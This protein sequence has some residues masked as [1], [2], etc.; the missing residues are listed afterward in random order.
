M[1]GKL[2]ILT[3]G[4]VLLLAG[5]CKQ[6]YPPAG[7]Y[8]KD[9]TY[10]ERFSVP[11]DTVIKIPGDSVSIALPAVILNADSIPFKPVVKR[12][13]RATLTVK[14]NKDK[15]LNIGC[16][17][18]SAAIAAKVLDTYIQTH[19]QQTK[20]VT[21]TLPPEKYIPLF[22]KTLAWTGGIFLLLLA[23][24]TFLKIKKLI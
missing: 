15:V 4:V 10:T 7:S 1:K 20:T 12:S 3:I 2:F 8:E 14:V 6:Q 22:V 19:R 9:S 17:C 5:C 16:N 24:A 11:R 21:I 23:V 13:G 18:D